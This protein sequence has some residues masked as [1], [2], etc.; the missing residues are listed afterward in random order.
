MM[1]HECWGCY[2]TLQS[3][4]GKYQRC[5][6]LSEQHNPPLISG[7]SSSTRGLRCGRM[8][9]W[10]LLSLLT[11]SR[12]TSKELLERKKTSLG[13]RKGHRNQLE[14][15][16]RNA[17]FELQ[18]SIFSR[19]YLKKT[20]LFYKL[21]FL[22]FLYIEGLGIE[23]RNKK[24]RWEFFKLLPYCQVYRWAEVKSGRIPASPWSIFQLRQ[25]WKPLS[26]G[27]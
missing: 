21:W 17:D 13:K 26:S 1:S 10:R 25:Q 23:N 12:Q 20:K 5:T 15:K 24:W 18:N 7:I 3:L 4:L 16:N 8:R 19:N 14:V 27:F 6:E 11:S 2:S 22:Y 9:Y